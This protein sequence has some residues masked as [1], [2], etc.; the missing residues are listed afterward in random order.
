MNL[1]D[2]EAFLAIVSMGSISKTAELLYISQS[3]VS[4][5]L[6]SLEEELGVTLVE[7][8]KG[9]RNVELTQK[10]KDFVLIAEK[11]MQLYRETKTFQLD[12]RKSIA[13][14]SV[15]SLNLFTF[16]SFYQQM[17]LND[18]SM[19]LKITT[20]QSPEIYEFVENRSVDVGMVLMKAH[21]QNVN[22]RPIFREEM[23][24]VRSVKKQNKTTKPDVLQIKDLDFSNEVLINW[25]PEFLKWHDSW[26]SPSNYPKVHVDTIAMIMHFLKGDCWSLIPVSI[27]S[28][29]QESY[30]IQVSILEE[31]P[32]DR[33]CYILTNKHPK[34][35][36]VLN[37][38]TFEET[39][40]SYLIDKCDSLNITLL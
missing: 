35:T 26:C 7:R 3:T 30:P 23:A 13:I 32:P 28:I 37:I 10:G 5:R 25:S 27:I 34:Q 12:N 24:V 1:S 38:R 18:K 16:A 39:L 14:S 40:E 6:K 31:G 36:Q 15:D 21:S 8:H 29:L 2:V 4:M 19:S 17:I 33:I 20:H 22:V 11:L 9:Y